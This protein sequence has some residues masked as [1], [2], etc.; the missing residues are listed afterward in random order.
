MEVNFKPA[1]NKRGKWLSPLTVLQYDANSGVVVV[2]LSSG[3]PMHTAVE[4]ICV[5]VCN[6]KFAVQVI[7][8]NDQLTG[9][10]DEIVDES[11]QNA[12]DLH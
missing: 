9:I 7:E 2:L 11:S 8:I 6:E 5:A 10:F 1:D 3:R 12:I 4:D